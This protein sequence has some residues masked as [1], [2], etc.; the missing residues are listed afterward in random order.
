MRS[1]AH[2]GDVPAGSFT[3]PTDELKTEK[4]PG[5]GLHRLRWWQ[6]VAAV[7]FL[8]AFYTWVFQRLDWLFE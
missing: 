4:R 7:V 2:Q 3:M 8:V 1:V 6:I 5:I